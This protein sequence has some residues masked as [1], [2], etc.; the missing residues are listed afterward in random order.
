MRH[1]VLA[2]L[3]LCGPAHAYVRTTSERSGKPLFWAVR[4]IPMQPDSR[5]SQDM[6]LPLFQQT[7]AKAARNWT[8]QTHTCSSLVVFGIEA[9]GVVDTGPDDRH[10]V[11]FRDHVWEDNPGI[12]AKTVLWHLD[13]PGKTNDGLILDADIKLNGV[14]FTFITDP[15]TPA[16]RGTDVADLESTLT[17]EL[18]HVMGLGH[19]CWDESGAQPI[20][21]R[22]QPVLKCAQ[23]DLPQSVTAATMFPY[24][25]PPGSTAMRNVTA[26]DVRGICEPYPSGSDAACFSKI[27]GGCGFLATTP[28]S[29]GWICLVALVALVALV[30]LVSFRRARARR[31]P[32]RSDR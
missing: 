12:V 11:T 23:V 30:G 25:S 6:G 28:T 3:V 29:S 16:R 5:G 26:D 17:H 19:T 15:A 32:G 4:C 8:D 14:E 2:L 20:D 21:D 27:E 18:G 7:L 22:G 10:V 13:A 1:L 31:R 9:A 24:T